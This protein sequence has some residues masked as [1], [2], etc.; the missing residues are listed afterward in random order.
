[1][2]KQYNES[3]EKI[4]KNRLINNSEEKQYDQWIDDEFNP[5]DMQLEK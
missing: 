4:G 3:D 5:N 1:M 2:E